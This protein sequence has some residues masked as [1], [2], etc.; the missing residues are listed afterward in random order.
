MPVG[1][2]LLV[3]LLSEVKHTHAKMQAKQLNEIHS[4]Y[5]R[6]V[7][8]HSF[9]IVLKLAMLF[10]TLCSG[11]M[12]PNYKKLLLRYVLL[13]VLLW[14]GVSNGFYPPL[15]TPRKHNCYPVID[16]VPIILRFKINIQLQAI[17]DHKGKI[18]NRK[19][20]LHICQTKPQEF[21]RFASFKHK[22]VYNIIG[23]RLMCGL[24]MA[25][26]WW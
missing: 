18:G 8:T 13:T 2:N 24:T 1:I 6:M 10:L 25:F 12:K 9:V 3:F 16:C 19:H 22:H 7:C 14:H 26:G 11:W 17:H 20:S 23:L 15:F 5:D 4:T 21:R